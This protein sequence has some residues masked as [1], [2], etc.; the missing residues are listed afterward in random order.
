MTGPEAT[1]PNLPRHLHIIQTLDINRSGGLVSVKLVHESM[2]RCGI[3]SVLVF[4][5]TSRAVEIPPGSIAVTPLA[6]NRFYFGLR[7]AAIIREQVAGVDAVHVHGLYTYLN[8]V[9]GQCCRRLGK[10]LVYHP[11]GTLAPAYLRRGRLK[12]QCVLWA[13]ENANFRNVAAW[14]ALSEV[15][16]GQIR[17]AVPGANV[18]VV[19]NGVAMPAEASAPTVAEFRPGINM[20]AGCR[21]FLFLSRVAAVKGVDLLV[22]AWLAAGKQLNNCELWIAGPDFDGSAYTAE[23]RLRAAGCRNVF[24]LGAVTDREKDWL[25]RSAD[26]FVLPSRGE[27]QS[28]AIL[29]AMAYGTPVLLTTTC[30]FPLAAQLG[31]GLECEPN[32]PAIRQSLVAFGTSGDSELEE[33]GSRGRELVR[34]HYNIDQVARS[35]DH[36]IAQILKRT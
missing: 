18:I 9:A 12:K 23:E 25:F 11:H 8:L 36:G 34:E 32:E 30:Y 3:E 24:V 17:A 7:T 2:L 33:M 26:V 1:D 31:A 29:E 35:L 19:P 13:F 5:Q 15:E 22:S 14:R 27:G 10:A 16:A 20:R 21:R 4:N 28:S 6:G